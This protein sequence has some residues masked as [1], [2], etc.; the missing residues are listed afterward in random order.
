MRF[1]AAAKMVIHEKVMKKSAL[2]ASE[3]DVTSKSMPTKSQITTIQNLQSNLRSLDRTKRNAPDQN[4]EQ[5][6]GKEN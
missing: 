6:M 1:N 2:P 3:I 4:T 5:Q